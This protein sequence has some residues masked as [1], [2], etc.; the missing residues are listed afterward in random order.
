V[1]QGRH[2]RLTEEDLEILSAGVPEIDLISPHYGRLNAALKFGRKKTTTYAI[3]VAPSFG[4]MSR[5]FPQPGGRFLNEYDMQEKRRVVF[6][7]SEI[8]TRLSDEQSAVGKV[9]EIDGIVFTVIGVMQPKLQTEMSNGPDANRAVMPAT[10]YKT[11]YGDR[12]L[13][14]IIVRPKDIM[15][16]GRMIE[17]IKTLLA[18]RHKFNPEDSQA[19]WT[20]DL[21]EG[22][23]SGFSWCHR[24]I[25]VDY[26][27]RWGG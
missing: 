2:I 11:L 10:T 18:R 26:R 5:M 17:N 21:I 19:I 8:K 25:D 20:S 6:L 1:P 27:G 12:Y 23:N 9:I 13:G 15:Q 22:E 4:D 3:G 16:T 24:S 14:F 7:G